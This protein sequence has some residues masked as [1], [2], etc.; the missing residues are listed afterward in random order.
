VQIR[1][2]KKPLE[3][4]IELG[5]HRESEEFHGSASFQREWETD[6]MFKE[7]AETNHV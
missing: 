3:L 1:R 5:H 4:G 7:H 6:W 2:G